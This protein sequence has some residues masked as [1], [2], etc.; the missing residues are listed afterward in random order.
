MRASLFYM[1]DQ[2]MNCREQRAGSQRARGVEKPNQAAAHDRQ[3]V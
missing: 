1:V 3:S 2:R